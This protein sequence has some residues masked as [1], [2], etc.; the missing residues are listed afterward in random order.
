MKET[1][2]TPG[3][4]A[5]KLTKAINEIHKLHGTEQFP[6]NVKEV[7]LEFSK[8]YFPAS[9]ISH[10]IANDSLSNGIEGTLQPRN[11]NEWA[12][13]YRPT[14]CKGRDNFTV[15]HE[16]AHY[17][18]HREVA[19]KG[20]FF[21]STEKVEN[22]QFPVRIEREANRFASFLLMPFDDFRAQIGNSLIS[23][24]L[25][26]HLANRYQVSRTASML[27][28][29]EG[30]AKRA[31]LVYSI[32]GH[33]YWHYCSKGLLKSSAYKNPKKITLPV[34]EQSLIHTI[35]GD[36]TVLHPFGVWA[37]E[38]EVKEISFSYINNGLNIGVHLL[39]YPDEAASN[40]N[41]SPIC[42]LFDNDDEQMIF[43]GQKLKW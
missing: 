20:G 38:E 9:R 23:L 11:N 2:N 24:E 33:I 5:I 43:D 1:P 12:I 36:S 32:D 34:P 29:L 37:D 39:I 7:A 14:G 17:L 6:V 19:P 22:W 15:V 16:L 4:W 21:C 28:W 35:G 27:R 25:I 31:K 10:V 3:K 30:C 8:Q 41:A 13:I 42:R 18:S 26:D 40:N